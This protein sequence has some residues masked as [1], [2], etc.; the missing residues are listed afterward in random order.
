MFLTIAK[1]IALPPI[2]ILLEEDVPSKELIIVVI[3]GRIISL[4][5]VNDVEKLPGPLF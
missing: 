3:I 4:F 2:S 5:V 1:E